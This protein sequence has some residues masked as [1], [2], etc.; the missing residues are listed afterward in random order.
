[1]EKITRT[2]G[3]LAR[4]DGPKVAF[5]CKHLA[6]LTALFS[7]LLLRLASN[8]GGAGNGPLVRADR[9]QKRAGEGRSPARFVLF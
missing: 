2:C 7:S 8:A 4:E 6:A 1:V 5:W 3:K 9:K